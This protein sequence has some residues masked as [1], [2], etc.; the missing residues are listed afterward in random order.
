M[1]NYLDFLRE[2]KVDEGLIAGIEDFR[3]KYGISSDARV[4]EPR[5]RYYGK[6]IWE[7]AIIAML[8]GK[9]LLLTGSKA[10]GKN[11]LSENLAAV[12]TRPAYYISFHV[13]VD[14]ASLIG[15]DTFKDGRVEFREGPVTR[16]AEEGGFAVLDE[17]NMA[18]NEALAVLHSML[19]Y[20]R[21]ID[22]PGYDLIKVRPEARFIAT[23]NYGYAGT[24]EINEALESRF[25]VIHMPFISRESMVKLLQ[26][27]FPDLKQK[28]AVMFSDLFFDI[29]NKADHSEISEKPVDLRGMID[30]INMARAGLELNS[31]L[32]MGITDK[33]SDEYER[34]VVNDVIRGRIPRKVTAETIFSR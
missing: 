19:D 13:N 29:K 1:S 11:V 6:E 17:I 10:T 7:K 24:R 32:Q 33:A 4:P 15:A 31:A 16:C 21:I 3:E 14:A 22:I 5:F 34:N 18:K 23:M 9:N 2:Q 8:T 25:V 20:R 30:A 28:Y 27:T 26:D 12:F